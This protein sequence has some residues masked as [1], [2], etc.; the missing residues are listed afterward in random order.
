MPLQYLW[1]V[2]CHSPFLSGYG[3]NLF[4]HKVDPDLDPDPD[5]WCS[6][7]S[8]IDCCR[9]AWKD[10]HIDGHLSLTSRYKNSKPQTHAICWLVCP[11]AC[12]MLLHCAH[13]HHIHVYSYWLITYSNDELNSDAKWMHVILCACSIVRI[14]SHVYWNQ[15]KNKI[16]R[17]VTTVFGQ[18]VNWLVC[19]KKN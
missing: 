14:T 6:V 18:K 16:M 17:F 8:A 11:G 15:F 2:V 5:K 1:H 7:N 19:Q 4:T 9:F 10:G 12:E 3:V 13:H